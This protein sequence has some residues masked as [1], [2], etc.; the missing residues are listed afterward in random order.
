LLV[1]SWPESTNRLL[2]VDS[3][4]IRGIARTAK[5][6]ES[7]LSFRATPK[8]VDQDG[9]IEKNRRH[10]S[11]ATLIAP[12]LVANPAA[13]IIIPFMSTIRDRARD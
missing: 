6:Q 13:G 12:T 4:C 2:D 8:D 5:R 1:L 9:R 7:A 11:D 3:A 10:L